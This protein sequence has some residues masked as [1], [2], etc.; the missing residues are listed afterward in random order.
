MSWIGSEALVV[1]TFLL[2]G[3]VS[4][5]VFHS[6]TP[7]LR[8][9]GVER[10]IQA[11]MFTAV[12]QGLLT[13]A[14]LI[15]GVFSQVAFS[16]IGDWSPATGRF[17]PDIF[18]SLPLAVAV[19][20]LAAYFVNHDTLHKLLRRIG[21]TRETSYPSDWYLVFSEIHPQYVILHLTGQRRLYGFPE[22]WP[23]LSTEGHFHISE[24][25]WLVDDPNEGNV[26]ANVMLIPASEVEM[27]QFTGIGPSEAQ[28]GLG[29]G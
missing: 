17:L 28:S 4:A 2:P 27:V 26:P 18:L 22:H 20:V 12:V 10:L 24:A 5:A 16:S 13:G 9:T 15:G 25:E 8:P 6:L 21:L 19:S 1:L 11:L 7:H 23:N 29:H 14:L 3:F